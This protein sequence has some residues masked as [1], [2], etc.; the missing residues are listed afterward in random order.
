MDITRLARGLSVE[1]MEIGLNW[2]L[3][4]A[5][6]AGIFP[7]L[8]AS[9]PSS[10]LNPLYELLL[11]FS[12]RGKIM[13][14]SSYLSVPQRFFLHFYLLGVAWTTVLLLTTWYY[15]SQVAPLGSESLSLSTAAG[16]L[17]GLSHISS[18][19][20]SRIHTADK[21]YKVW[22]SVFLLL[23]ME[24]QV[25]RR[26]YETLYV[27]K[28]SNSARMHIFG[29]LMGIFYYTAAPLSLCTSF[30][31]VALNFTLDKLAVLKLAYQGVPS[32]EFDWWGYLR[33]LANLGWHQW[34]GAALFAW[35][36]VHQWRCHAILGSLRKCR[37]QSDEYV[38]PRGDWFEIVSSPHYLA[39]IV[40]Y[41]GLLVASGGTD[42][43]IWL[44]LGFVVANLAFAA[45][46]TH[47]WYLHKFEDY[48]S[49]R[50]VIFPFVY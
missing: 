25:L 46:E 15:A 21:R 41:L 47:R 44:L 20:K 11:G 23:L 3:R 31:L 7:L 43:T 48:P 2:S 1:S 37:E 50:R 29:Y 36:W 27:F 40:V 24:M 13:Q 4:V 8:V 16:H 5:W 12:K 34:A 22:V 30:V 42:F 32:M 26:L 6:I 38:I 33:P 45:A 14:S 49:N 28:Y 10:R 19:Y 17:T 9:L 18:L 39:E 35:G